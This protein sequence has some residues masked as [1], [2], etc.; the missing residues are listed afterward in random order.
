MVGHFEEMKEQGQSGNNTAGK[1]GSA[2]LASSKGDK[3]DSK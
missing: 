1:T 3:S 2:T